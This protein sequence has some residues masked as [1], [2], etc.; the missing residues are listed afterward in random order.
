MTDLELER[1]LVAWRRAL[2]STGDVG[3]DD[4]E[5]IENHL[6]EEIRDLQSRGL[7]SSEALI[8]ATRRVG[9]THQL[10][11]E[12]FKV[13]VNKL[14]KRLAVTENGYSAWRELL[15]IVALVLV[16]V[17][18]SQT[19]YL[20]G[21]SYFDESSMR[22]APFA[23][24]W[25]IPSMVLWFCYRHRMS[26]RRIAGSVIALIGLHLFA[27]FFPF[28]K[29]SSTRVLVMLHIPFLSW[30]LLYPLAL[31]RAWRS[32]AGAVHYLRLSAEAFIYAVLVGMGGATLVAIGLTIFASIG[33]QLEAFAINHVIVASIYGAPVVGV[34]LADRKRQVIENFA[35][36]LARIFVPLFAF[37]II[38]FL[39]TTVVN[40]ARPQDDRMLLL[41]MNA[42]LLLVGAMLFYDVSARESRSV[43]RLSDWGNVLLTIA[44][45]ALDAYTLLGISLRLIERGI[46]PNR[47]AIFGLNAILLTHLSFLL[48]VYV[49][50]MRGRIPFRQIEVT[51]VKALPVYG[52]WLVAVVV[53]FPVMFRGA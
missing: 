40:R 46:S 22:W 37:V 5:E 27:A 51:V 6:R 11:R 52:V 17:T 44:A 13:N 9:E 14:W 34:V 3:S 41:A 16:A 33:V 45:L 38:A 43:Y 50:F 36:T 29:E 28:A 15:V 12:Y 25:I 1:E 26:P 32:I 35:P 47:V 53:A 10:S 7:S 48:H 20:F 19:P 30:L 49:R 8:V 4:A 31:D 18:L 23:S 24:I 39:L 21:G 2:E 42:V